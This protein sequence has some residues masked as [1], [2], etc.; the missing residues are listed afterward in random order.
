MAKLTTQ[1]GGVTLGRGIAAVTGLVTA[2]ILSRVM[3]VDNYGTYRQ[4]WLIFFALAPILELGIPPSVSFFMPQLAR[5]NVKTYLI[6]NAL[7]LLCS[8]LM[9][10]LTFFFLGGQIERLFSNPGLVQY[11]RAFALFP[12]LTISFNVT[13]NTLI[14][15]GRSGIAGLVSGS[16]ALIQTCLILPAVLSGATLEQIFYLLS[17]WALLRWLISVGA[18]MHLSRHLKFTWNWPELR[19]NLTFALPIGAAMMAAVLAR[20][21][22]K[23]IISSSFTTAQFA[24]Y[25]N[26]SYEIPLISV[27][28]IS[29]TAVL[30]PALVRAYSA[31]DIPEVKRLWHGSARRTAWLF[32]PSFIFL[33][34][35]ARPLIVFL[36]SDKYVDSVIVFRI[37]L[38]LL[39]L[40]IALYSA[41]LRALGNTRA[42]LI[43]SLGTCLLSIVLAIIL[44]RI[45][46]LGFTGPA[47][48]SVIASYWAAGFCINRAI[49]TLNWSWREFFPWQTL[50]AIMLVALAAAVPTIG[51]GYIIRGSGAIFQ[52][53]ILALTYASFYLVVGELSGAARP[54]EWIDAIRDLIE[55]R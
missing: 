54:R 5:D 3:T 33:F 42:I 19:T 50:W 24:I 14:A 29:V 18:F 47:I 46:A 30:V 10:G 1:A 39:P 28:T 26:G 34:I 16:S 27:L 49:K 13:E 25:A 31:K 11:L 36:F 7:V 6:Q 23:I 35:A 15:L 45:H 48:A 52:L 53:V 8:G 32:F 17:A 55:R 44:I 4:V 40:R 9:L 38:F 41:F 2:M 37:F 12:A 21:M 51:V 43:S 20:Q 22:D